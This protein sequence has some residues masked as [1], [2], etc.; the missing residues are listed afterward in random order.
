M[1]AAK[2]IDKAAQ[3]GERQRRTAK[4]DESQCL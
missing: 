4:S 2:G 3:G 1:G